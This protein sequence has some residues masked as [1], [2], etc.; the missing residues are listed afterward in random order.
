MDRYQ[1]PWVLYASSYNVGTPLN[2]QK[3]P[4]KLV[5]EPSA[6][7][8]PPG[9]GRSPVIL[10]SA[11]IWWFHSGIRKST[12]PNIAGKN[13]RILVSQVIIREPQEMLGLIFKT[14]EQ[15]S[16]ILVKPV[17]V[18]PFLLV[19]ILY[20]LPLSLIKKSLRSPI[21]YHNPLLKN[22]SMHLPSLKRK[23]I[24]APTS[25]PLQTRSRFH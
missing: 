16:R 7:M 1:L 5:N 19:T 23:S 24:Q 9:M 20:Q 12:I 10:R 21:N 18:S 17:I 3:S 15:K 4:S 8:E 6:T 25:H 14:Y 11:P 2:W 13:P 22:Q